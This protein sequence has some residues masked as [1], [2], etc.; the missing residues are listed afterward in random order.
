M[1]FRSAAAHR[2]HTRMARAGC[3]GRSVVA[4]PV[5]KRPIARMV[6]REYIGKQCSRRGRRDASRR[7][8]FT[9]LMLPQI[10][11]RKDGRH[12][13]ELRQRQTVHTICECAYASIRAR[14]SGIS[15]SAAFRSSLL[16]SSNLKLRTFRL[17]RGRNMANCAMSRSG[18]FT[19]GYTS[20]VSPRRL[21]AFASSA[22]AKPMIER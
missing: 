11:W 7:L 9:M 8:T 19:D 5:K 22:S 13:G 4:S 21:T 15:G 18:V 14:T 1:L 16:Q 17:T 3:A 10:F 12:S 20:F 6:P 2:H